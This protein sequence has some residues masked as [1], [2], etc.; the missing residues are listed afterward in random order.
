MTWLAF[1][2]QLSH[3][4][5][6]AFEGGCFLWTSYELCALLGFRHKLRKDLQFQGRLLS[7]A[8]HLCLEVDFFLDVFVMSISRI[9]LAALAL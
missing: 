7:F 9:G 5:L 8:W 2:Q 3:L 6:N 1:Y 4:L